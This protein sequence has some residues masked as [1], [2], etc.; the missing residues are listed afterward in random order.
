MLLPKPMSLFPAATAKAAV[1]TK[2]TRAH[3]SVHELAQLWKLSPALITSLF[4]EEPGVILVDSPRS[5]SPIISIPESVAARVY[6]RLL[7]P[8]R[9]NLSDDF[10]VFLAHNSHDKAIIEQ[11]AKSLRRRRLNVWFDSWS[12]PP[13]RVFQEEIERV[14]P[15]VRTVAIFVGHHG[16]G[17]WE[18]LEMRAAISNFVACG[19][20][21]IPVLL[22][23]ILD[24][25]HLPLFLREFSHVRFESPDDRA[26]LR[27]LAWGITAA[28]AVRAK[29]SS[30]C[31]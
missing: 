20:A 17:R 25:L 1:E 5:R 22:P 12:L 9:A 15:R 18:R 4:V 11:I 13:G 10:D 30:A 31:K 3:F 19:R 24:P 28:V 6:Q 23:G 2:H 7:V 8:R 26:A 21:V 29:K 14:L 27:Q 16:L